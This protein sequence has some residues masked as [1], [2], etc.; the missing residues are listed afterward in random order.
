V[1][2]QFNDPSTA[3]RT[4]HHARHE[5]L[6]DLS[7][8]RDDFRSQVAAGL[9]QKR[10]TLPCK[11]FYDQRGSKLFDQICELPE[12]YLTRAE[13]QILQSHAADM[14]G[15]LGPCCRVIE[16]GSGSSL[17]TRLLLDALQ[18]PAAYIP[19]DISREHLLDAAVRLSASYPALKVLP[20]CADYTRP[21]MV[22][23]CDGAVRT[24][25]YFPGST[26][27][28]FE[29][30]D[31]RA[32]LRS[33]A[34]QC[35]GGG[36]LLI[37]VDLKKDPGIL[38]AA[39][40]DAARVTAEFNLNLLHRI[41]RELDGTFAVDRFAHYAFYNP[42]LGRI[43]MHLVSQSAQSADAGGSTFHFREGETIFTESSHKYTLE[44][45]ES[46]ARWAGWTVQNVWTD[47]RRLFSV[48]YLT[49]S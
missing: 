39:Y 35:G 22:P 46:L 32:F 27:G 17:K 1:I 21:F 9:G 42:R 33:A 44:E 24:V 7:P 13:L 49:V 4:A 41:N 34:A 6:R 12:Y 29:P 16:Y 18:N 28:N 40:N 2:K 36:A 14:A 30:H 11:F 43:E 26:I 38:H 19:L 31:A 8:K 25:V 15:A 3:T 37:G 48:Q 5:R 23:E 20:V 10:K 47:S 45:F